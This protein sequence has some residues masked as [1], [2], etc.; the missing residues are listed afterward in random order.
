MEMALQTLGCGYSYFSK[1]D[2]RSGF[3]QLPID[4]K[5]RFKTAFATP[6]GLFE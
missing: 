5:D 3:W 6:F 4:P 1:F 2:L